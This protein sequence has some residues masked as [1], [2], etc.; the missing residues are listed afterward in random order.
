[1]MAE[2]DLNTNLLVM[3]SMSVADSQDG[4]PNFQFDAAY[5]AAL[6]T[7]DRPF[8]EWGREF[9]SST[10]HH[11][12][13]ESEKKRL[14]SFESKN[15]L[16]QNSSVYRHHAR[17]TD[18]TRVWDRWLLMGM[19]GFTTALIG[20]F[21]RQFVTLIVKH[22]YELARPHLHDGEWGEA[23]VIVTLYSLAFVLA[24]SILVVYV[25]PPAAASGIPEVI[26]FLNGVHVPK[27]FNIKTLVIKF[28]SCVCA[29]GSGLPVGPEGPMIHMG[30]MVGAGLSQ[31]RSA[32][33]GFTVFDSF[34]ERFRN[35][36]DRRDFITAGVATGVSAAF[37]APVGGL[38]FAMEEVSSFWN[39]RLGWMI[40]FACMTAV[41]TSD[42]FNSA[43]HGFQYAKGTFGAFS[44]SASILFQPEFEVK[45]HILIMLPTA[46]IGVIGGVLG[47]L[48][49]FAN[50]KINRWRARYIAPSK[51]RRV[52]EPCIIMILMAT[53]G[54]FL[55]RA[56]DCR[57]ETNCV[58][59][60]PE[61]EDLDDQNEGFY[62]RCASTSFAVSSDLEKYS[63]AAWVGEEAGPRNITYNDLASLLFVQGEEAIH[64]L[65]SRGTGYELGYGACATML[66]IYFVG[67]CWAAGT[68][69][70][71]GLVVPMLLIGGCYGRIVG[72]M[73]L[74]ASGGD[75]FAHA[76]KWAWI[77]PGV[78][79]L[80][81]AGSFF[82]G[83]S[84][85]TMSLTVIMVEISDDIHLLLP[86]MFSI[87]I[88]KWIADYTTHS[89]YHA[90]LELKCMPFLDSDPPLAENLDLYPVAVLMNS[91]PV[92]LEE[93]TSVREAQAVLKHSHGAFPVVRM[94]PDG[95]QLV[96]LMLRQSLEV[97]LMQPDIFFPPD[98]HPPTTRLP[99][100]AINVCE[101]RNRV[102]FRGETKVSPAVAQLD[103]KIDLRP[104][105]DESVL[106]V[107]EHYSVAR[108][109][110]VFRGM[111]L[112]HLPVVNHKHVVLGMITRKD[113]MGYR[114]HEAIHHFDEHQKTH[115][116][117]VA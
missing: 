88:S 95:P 44:D 109:Y 110:F 101:L 3:D 23:W 104:Y 10:T 83:V 63:C 78:F 103:M 17:L 26:A 117:S 79:A 115:S 38:L 32:T 49:T 2:T 8:F 80:I 48:F 74:D 66:I 62:Y 51:W 21:L 22:K 47:T 36:R 15:Y 30:A 82:G 40:F 53:L 9:E 42:L 11:T 14:A 96:G 77:D 18:S 59:D 41:F 25:Q 27:V 24:S 71:S 73:V 56:F 55:P 61:G 100:D 60:L 29:V 54:V 28:F 97:L 112:R 99:Y 72:L 91:P 16:P 111:S 75:I 108:T 64:Q 39:Q 114:I 98:G 37:G 12:F 89:L 68:A 93:I 92:C 105:M 4:D 116:H 34:T 7:E 81:G 57:S 33:L 90:L 87:M 5:D 65:F 85:L 31:G 94:S 50:I 70:S 67:A 84:R 86:I 13:T 45:T 102:H 113:L 69:V 52:A 76:S 19:I 20:F 107:P 6:E 46:L 1:M 35:V 43:F 106:S 58:P